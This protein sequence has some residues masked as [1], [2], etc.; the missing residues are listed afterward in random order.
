M[1][2]DDAD[3]ILALIA[4]LSRWSIGGVL[5]L[6]LGLGAAFTAGGA[7]GAAGEARLAVPL[8]VGARLHPELAV[9]AV[10]WLSHP[11]G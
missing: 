11:Q 8:P 6:R 5:D 10:V 1:G 3:A 4:T 9:R 2:R 7:N